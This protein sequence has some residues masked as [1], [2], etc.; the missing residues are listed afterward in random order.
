MSKLFE[1]LQKI[2]NK[3]GMYI[4]SASVSDLFHFLVGFKTALRELG[5]AATKEEM[6]FYREFQP[7]VQKKYHVSTSNSWAKIIMLHCKSEQEGFNTFYKLLEE[8]QHHNKNVGGDL[9]DAKSYED[10]KH[11]IEEVIGI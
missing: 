5:I 1:I 7:W 4:G 6:D 2:R 3:P 10:N 11:N 8:F 9:S